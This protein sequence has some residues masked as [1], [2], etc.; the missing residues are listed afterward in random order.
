MSSSYPAHG[1]C[2]S[3]SKEH[4]S[5]NSTAQ[6]QEELWQSLSLKTGS[7]EGQQSRVVSSLSPLVPAAMCVKPTATGSVASGPVAAGPVASAPVASASRLYPDPG[8]RNRTPV[9]MSTLVCAGQQHSTTGS[10]DQQQ[11]SDSYFP[12]YTFTP[13]QYRA[14]SLPQPPAFIPFAACLDQEQQ[15]SSAIS[16]VYPQQCSATSTV[17][18]QQYSLPAPVPLVQ[19]ITVYPNQSVEGAG[20][21][22]TVA[23]VPHSAAAPP[24]PGDS[25]Q[26]PVPQAAAAALSHSAG[27]ATSNFGYSDSEGDQP[28]LGYES[29]A[30]NAATYGGGSE[31]GHLAEEPFDVDGNGDAQGDFVPSP[32]PGQVEMRCSWRT[33]HVTPCGELFDSMGDFVEHVNQHVNAIS[34][35]HFACR[36]SNC[37]K[38]KGPF[39]ARYKLINHVRVH[40]G[41]QPFICSACNKRFARS[42]NWKIHMRLHT[43]DRPFGC[44]YPGCKKKFTNSSDRKKHAVVHTGER[45]SVCK[46]PGCDKVYTHPSSLRKHV[47]TCHKHATAQTDQ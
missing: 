7:G 39:K 47:S 36:W 22:A 5:S 20:R 6:R 43:G 2:T 38:E 10:L 18:P 19:V 27:Y 24:A 33:D 16:S 30:S 45:R 34:S 42:E 23:N 12:Q 13:L 40:T 17:H 3:S 4:T 28:T 41:E 9:T 14:A 11:F 35:R 46:Q 8:I 1:H 29:P 37:K 21:S 26:L 15:H 25:S 31:D 32:N 44:P